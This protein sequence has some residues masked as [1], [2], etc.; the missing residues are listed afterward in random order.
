MKTTA[1]L[2]VTLFCLLLAFTNCSQR[3]E[4]STGLVLIEGKINPNIVK[5]HIVYLYQNKDSIKL[6]FAEKT[7][8]DS[9]IIDQN[10]NY[11]FTLKNLVKPGFIDLGT[12]EMLL[13]ANYFV[14]PNDH[15]KLN[16]GGTELPAKLEVS[17]EN[18]GRYNYF[19][20]Q[21]YDSFY[22]KPDVKKFYYIVSNFMYA[23]DYAEYINKRR[24]QQI[25]YYKK[26]FENDKI[27]STFKFY[28]ESEIDYTWANDKLWFLW[29]K[30]IRKEVKPVDTSY[31]DFIKVIQHNNTASLICPNYSRF[32][33]LYVRELYDN[34]MYSFSPDFISSIEKGKIAI[35]KYTGLELKMA[36]FN[37]LKSEI[38]SFDIQSRVKATDPIIRKLVDLSIEAT[39]DSSYFHY[40]YSNP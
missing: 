7:L 39:H 3:H 30:R 12:K 29:K 13:G 26:Y 28:F 21:F 23:P 35:E 4:D 17:Y 24:L 2:I 8:T 32:I 19:L 11:K 25:N 15:I 5:D 36:L 31:F 22:Y 16:Y 6:L 14:S 33:N 27:D 40:T 9:V 10:G 34:R 1:T 20:Q 18:L 37:I 38:N